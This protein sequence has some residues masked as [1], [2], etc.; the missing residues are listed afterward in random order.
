[1]LLKRYTGNPVIKP[2]MIPDCTNVFNS[3]AV[4]HDGKV[5]ML[6][7]IW[8]NEWE[9]CF[10]RAESSNGIDF[11]F[12]RRPRISPLSEYPYGSRDGIFDTRITPFAEDGCCYVTYNVSSHLG[13]RIRLAR[14]FDLDTYEDLGFISAPD[15]RNCVLFSEKIGGKYARLE[16][17]NVEGSG[18]IY[19]SY[20][21]DL[22]HWGETELLLEHNRNYW[23]SYKIGPGAP[24]LKTPEGWLVIYH[25]TRLSMNGQSYQAGGILLDLD[26]PRKIIGKSDLC[27]LAPD[28]PYEQNGR[29]PN[30]VFPTALV[31]HPEKGLLIYYGAADC[32][33]CLAFAEEKELIAA[34][35]K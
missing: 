24:P 9:P 30:V 11:E 13:G 25:G 3:G 31:R 18:D 35:L 5:V 34:C 17:P 10:I 2:E 33:I 26:D 8:G 16:R 12:D 14:T 1:M 27:W 29:C 20:S 28:L 22:I 19:I 32:S 6:L 21:P 4:W 15:H 23:E 7:N